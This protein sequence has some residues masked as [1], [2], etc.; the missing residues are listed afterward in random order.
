[1]AKTIEKKSA[2]DKDGVLI[3]DLPEHIISEDIPRLKI[4][5]KKNV[6]LK[7]IKYMMVILPKINVTF[8]DFLYS[9]KAKELPYSPELI[10]RASEW[11]ILSQADRDLLVE[12]DPENYK[13]DELNNIIQEFSDRSLR[14]ANLP[15]KL[16]TYFL[17]NGFDENDR[18]LQPVIEI[19]ELI[20]TGTGLPMEV[21]EESDIYILSEVFIRIFFTPLEE[22]KNSFFLNLILSVLKVNIPIFSHFMQTEN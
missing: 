14:M 22:L 18:P 20:K 12:S 9:M 6:T 15:I 13:P 21:I 10:K 1:M 2:R 17:E 16:G 3:Q 4:V 5:R 19:Y 8:D 11:E 7:A